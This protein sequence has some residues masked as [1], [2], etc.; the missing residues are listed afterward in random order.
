MLSD[1]VTHVFRR[2]S[3]ESSITSAANTSTR[4]IGQLS[5]RVY[6]LFLLLPLLRSFLRDRF[7][8]QFDIGRGS[9]W[10]FGER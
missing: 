6:D 4:A 7:G 2:S 3:P 8:C 5:D 1:N 10:R 9:L